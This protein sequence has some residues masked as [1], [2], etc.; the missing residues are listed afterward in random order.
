MMRWAGWLL[1]GIVLGWWLGTVATRQRA[2]AEA[3]YA[4]AIAA[5]A[6]V[7][8]EEELQACARRETSEG[9]HRLLTEERP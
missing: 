9:V 3:H 2:Q 5:Q 4:E 8:M 1:C 6:V 7:L